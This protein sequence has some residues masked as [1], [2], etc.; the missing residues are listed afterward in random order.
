[1]DVIRAADSVWQGTTTILSTR[2][3]TT[4]VTIGTLASTRTS[5]IFHIFH[6]LGWFLLHHWDQGVSLFDTRAGWNITCGIF[7]TAMLVIRAA[8]GVWQWTTVVLFICQLA[9]SVTVG[10]LDFFVWANHA[11]RIVESSR[12][13]DCYEGKNTHELKFI[14]IILHHRLSSARGHTIENF[15]SHFVR[16]YFYPVCD[17]DLASTI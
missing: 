16:P 5:Y 11:F 8:N 14:K 15:H 10:T 6:L 9:T 4:G 7:R 13:N 2:Q 3:L 1:M 12:T 17:R